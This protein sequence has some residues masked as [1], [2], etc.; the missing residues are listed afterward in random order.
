MLKRK[1][2]LTKINKN[3][4]GLRFSSP[5]FNL[6]VSEGGEKTSRFGFI[7][8][9]KVSKNAVLRNKTKRVLAKALEGL[10]KKINTNRDIVII[11]KKELD[12]TKT[13]EVKKYFTGF[14]KKAKI[15]K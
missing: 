2:R 11:S 15:L 4:K 14:F 8:S 13:E 3:T 9:K 6:V 1:N 12:W 10:I 5:F 7:V